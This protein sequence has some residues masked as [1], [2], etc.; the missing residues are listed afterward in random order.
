MGRFVEG[1]DRRQPVLL[2]S[3]LDVYV[4]QDNPARVID[5]F[6]DELDLAELGFEVALAATGRPACHPA[7]VQPQ[8]AFPD[9]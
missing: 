1:E 5:V 4:G 3:C 8:L 7:S 6:V 2:P 9:C